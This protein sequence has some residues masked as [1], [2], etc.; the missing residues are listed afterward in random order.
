MPR[1]S[2]ERRKFTPNE[3]ARMWGVAPEKIIGFIRAGELNA[4]DV[5]RGNRRPRFLIDVDDLRAFERRRADCPQPQPTQ[6][7][8][9]RPEGV[10]QYY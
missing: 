8:R 1:S 6:P 9:R 4:I 5:S 7:R 10:T 2:T 3:V